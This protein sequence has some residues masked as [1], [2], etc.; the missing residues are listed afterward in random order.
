MCSENL[1]SNLRKQGSNSGRLNCRNSFEKHGW[2]HPKEDESMFTAITPL[3][4]FSEATCEHCNAVEANLVARL[5]KYLGG[6]KS[7]LNIDCPPSG[8]VL[9]C[10]VKSSFVQVGQ[11]C[12]DLKSGLFY[13]ILTS[14]P[15]FSSKKIQLKWTTFSSALLFLLPFG[16]CRAIALFNTLGFSIPCG[17][18]L[19]TW[20]RLFWF[21]F[22]IC[23]LTAM[24]SDDIV[25]S[26]PADAFPCRSWHVLDQNFMQG[27]VQLWF[28]QWFWTKWVLPRTPTSRRLPA[29]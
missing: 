8:E 29:S 10:K 20:L 5:S 12:F 6:I 18:V 28:K 22:L 15:I 27:V 19:T 7:T 17:L 9:T 4:A 21:F 11:S 24:V 14:F 23:L 25:C 1:A 26:M 13:I 16:S 2:K 3:G